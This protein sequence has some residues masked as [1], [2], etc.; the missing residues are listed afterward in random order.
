MKRKCIVVVVFLLGIMICACGDVSNDRQTQA[1]EIVT[2]ALSTKEASFCDFKLQLNSDGTAEI[3][4]FSSEFLL[5]N[6]S[7]EW[8]NEVRVPAQVKIEGKNYQIKNVSKLMAEGR[9]IENLVFEEG[10]EEIH[11]IEYMTV[12]NIS[13]PSTL[14]KVG[15][16]KD[17]VY[18][19]PPVSGVQNVSLSANNP[20]L[21]LCNG[22]I[23]SKDMTQALWTVQEKETVVFPKGVKK[24]END[25]FYD[26]DTVTKVSMPDTVK[27]L[28]N[29]LFEGCKKLKTIKF[30]NA[31]TS[32]Q[33]VY[34]S[35]TKIKILT[36]PE[37]V[38]KISLSI[39]G[40]KQLKKIKINKKNKYFKMEGGFLLSKNGKK[41]YLVIDKEKD[42]V[43][44]KTVR[45]IE[46]GAF[47]GFTGDSIKVRGKIEV[48]PYGCFSGSGISKVILP[49]TVELIDYR[50]FYECEYLDNIIMPKNLKEIGESAFEGSGLR[51]LTIPAKVKKI[52]KDALQF[53]GIYKNTSIRFLGKKPPK[54]YKNMPKNTGDGEFFW[55]EKVVVPKQSVN[56]YK[57][58]FKKYRYNKMVGK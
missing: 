14:K 31:L 28:G 44:P 54:I 56:K 6:L 3:T 49:D 5:G 43:T 52:E 40:M 41:L 19:V 24:I 33:G 50:A 2:H 15:R 25:V 17:A 34:L 11:D 21:T 39:G 35:S 22:I 23:Y 1:S 18:G 53:A 29:G 20:Y 32:L 58:A 55:P 7:G 9:N 48:I 57:K 16:N 37:K 38:K 8:V 45:E 42:I 4:G 51:T 27:T 47:S 12:T 36:I 46:P 26:N 13:F 10:I 30:S